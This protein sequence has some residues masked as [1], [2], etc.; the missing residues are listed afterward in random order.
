MAVGVEAPSLRR[1]ERSMERQT[2]VMYD[3]ARADLENA[4]DMYCDAGDKV[5]DRFDP[6]LSET[7]NLSRMQTELSV[8]LPRARELGC[9][10]H[11]ENDQVLAVDVPVEQVEPARR[12]AFE[13]AAHKAVKAGR[14]ER[15]LTPPT[16][17][18][19]YHF[20]FRRE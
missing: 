19:A 1:V 3:L 7:E 15:F 20:E 2:R 11:I 14:A 12:E 5:L 10:N 8:Q 13:A 18:G 4:R 6:K 9:L 16:H 17:P